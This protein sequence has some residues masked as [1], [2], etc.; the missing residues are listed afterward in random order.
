MRTWKHRYRPAG[1]LLA[2]GLLLIW[3][4]A[5]PARAETCP[6]IERGSDA[7][8]AI[9]AEVRLDFLR[10]RLAREHA[11][12]RTWSTAWG[13]TFGAMTFAQL[14]AIPLLPEDLAP[15]L[16]VG[17]ATS[18]VG[19]GLLLFFPLAVLSDQ[20]SLEA[21]LARADPDRQ[22][23]ALLAEAERVASAD[24]QNAAEGRGWLMHLANAVLGVGAG[25]VLGLGYDRWDSAAINLA[26]NLALGEAMIWTQPSGLEDDLE[27]YR[28]GQLDLEPDEVGLSW[29]IG[30][31]WLE[32]GAGLAWI[33]R[34]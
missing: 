6:S 8:A 13:A 31:V 34:F 25:L 28:R 2:L 7:L 30:P 29:G 9:P 10:A 1:S 23:C 19:V 5:L 22:V 20:P 32:G 26:A 21:S 18:A 4:G 14:V 27:R 3:L 15:D 12:A 24:A 17:A 16:V 11:R 33:G